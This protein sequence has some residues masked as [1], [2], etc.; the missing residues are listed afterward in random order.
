MTGFNLRN[1]MT[2]YKLVSI[3]NCT[4]SFDS[5]VCVKVRIFKLN[6]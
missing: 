5:F 1:M 3:N 2:E 4:L 6:M